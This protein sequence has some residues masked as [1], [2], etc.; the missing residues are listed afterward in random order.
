MWSD[1]V[2]CTEEIEGRGALAVDENEGR[3]SLSEDMEARGSA[4]WNWKYDCCSSELVED[5]GNDGEADGP[6]NDAS[7]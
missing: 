6:A 4:A 1:D 5:V 2:D 7:G 3:G